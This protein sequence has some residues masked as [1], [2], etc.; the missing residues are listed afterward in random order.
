MQRLDTGTLG[1]LEKQ[2]LTVGQQV[3]RPGVGELE[4]TDVDSVSL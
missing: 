1:K 2:N 4:L 3:S